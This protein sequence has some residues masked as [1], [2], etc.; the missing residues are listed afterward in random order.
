MNTSE[1]YLSFHNLS[2]DHQ[3]DKDM[4]FITNI[5]GE[6][7]SNNTKM[8]F[9]KIIDFFR[10][11][12]IAAAFFLTFKRLN[13]IEWFHNAKIL[14]NYYFGKNKLKI[15]STS[16]ERTNSSIGMNRIKY[17]PNGFKINTYDY[18]TFGI[19]VSTTI[20]V[21]IWIIVYYNKEIQHD[22]NN[23]LPNKRIGR[24]RKCRKRKKGRKK[25][26]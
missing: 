23:E 4:D 16:M 26:G 11:V 20:F 7:C 10:N 8:K 21:V 22:N 3:W 2:N 9:C 14:Y 25:G 17:E 6:C 12:F 24:I 15:L 1:H 18:L 19:L 13:E 5:S